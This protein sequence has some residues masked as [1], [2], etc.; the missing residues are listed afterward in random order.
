MGP[1]CLYRSS[2]DW[3]LIRLWITISGSCS[4]WFFFQQFCG[5]IQEPIFKTHILILMLILVWKTLVWKISLAN[6]SSKGLLF[7]YAK[8]GLE[9][10]LRQSR[11]LK[12]SYMSNNKICVF[13]PAW[14][15]VGEGCGMC[16]GRERGLSKVAAGKFQVEK[17]PLRHFPD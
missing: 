9:N 13:A 1:S 8:M 14:G 7:G 6:I 15:R 12:L 4:T 17:W 3:Q 11:K 16:S 10:S 2:L 5:Q